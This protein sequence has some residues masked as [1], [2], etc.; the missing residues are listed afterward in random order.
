ME[1][2]SLRNNGSQSFKN[3]PG[4]MSYGQPNDRWQ[5]ALDEEHSRPFIQRALELGINF[6]IRPMVYSG[7][8]SEEV[9]GRALHDFTSRDQV[10]IAHQSAWGDG[11]GSQRPWPFS[12]T[13]LLSS[14]DASPETPAHRFCGK[15]STKS[16]VGDYETPSM[17][18]WKA[19]HNIV[20][21][22]KAPLYWRL[23]HVCLAVCQSPSTLPML[24][25]WTRFCVQCS[26]HYN[27]VYRKKTR[28]AATLSGSEKSP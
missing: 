8:M 15:T 1:I 4:C 20:R 28:D 5:W 3:L 22:G 26:R 24:R 13:H 27:L 19:L 17:K 7:G 12:E 10:V 11:S 21:M 14:I 25:G 6:S 9:V 16:T 18:P 2:H 23:F